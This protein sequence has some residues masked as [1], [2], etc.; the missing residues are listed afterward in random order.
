MASG[1]TDLDFLWT[2][3]IEDECGLDER[4]L[5]TLTLSCRPLLICSLARGVLH[6]LRSLDRLEGSRKIR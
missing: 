4:Q 3:W 5:V 1:T 2:Y 6:T